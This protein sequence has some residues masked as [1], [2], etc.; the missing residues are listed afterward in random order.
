MPTSKSLLIT[1]ASTGIGRACALHMAALGWR[2][3][4]QLLNNLFPE[5]KI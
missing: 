4:A 2:V 5:I 3:I 1:G